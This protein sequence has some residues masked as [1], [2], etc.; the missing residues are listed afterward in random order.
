VPPVGETKVRPS[1]V[2]RGLP[3]PQPPKK[4]A[5]MNQQA[6]DVLQ[7]PTPSLEQ[8]LTQ[9]DPLANHTSVTLTDSFANTPH[10]EDIPQEHRMNRKNR[11][12]RWICNPRLWVFVVLISVAGVSFCPALIANKKPFDLV[13]FDSAPTDTEGV[14][15]SDTTSRSD[16][17]N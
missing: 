13:I 6:V 4:A 15:F 11:I 2:N 7:S 8:P 16:E 9:E 10:P 12:L 14:G 17:S 3:L 5:K 1:S